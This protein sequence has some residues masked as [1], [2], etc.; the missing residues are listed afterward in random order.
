MSFMQQRNYRVSEHLLTAKSHTH[1]QETID[2]CQVHFV[3]V[4]V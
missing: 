3:S 1:T 4:S 2:L